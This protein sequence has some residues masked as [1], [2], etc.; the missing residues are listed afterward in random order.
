MRERLSMRSDIS[1]IERD[2]GSIITSMEEISEEFAAYFACVYIQPS[3]SQAATSQSNSTHSPQHIPDSPETPTLS[4]ITLDEITVLKKLKTLSSKSTITPDGLPPIFLKNT[5]QSLLKPIMYIFNL[6]I[7]YGKSPITWKRVIVR[8]LHKKGS[9]KKASNYRPISLTFLERIVDQQMKL[10]YSSTGFFTDS[11]HGFRSRRSTVTC[12]LST[13][14]KWK[15]Q[16]Q[17]N[18]SVHALYMDFAKA[19]DVVNHSKLAM[20]KVVLKENCFHGLSTF[21]QTEHWRSLPMT[22]YLAPVLFLQE[23]FKAL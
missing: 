16:L 4:A 14:N 19:F 23:S 12:L 20:N 8:P 13:A 6:S 18:Q 22:F 15:K 21:L 9:H 3:T 5:A 11:Q 1:V 17:T 2:D 10:F 7:K